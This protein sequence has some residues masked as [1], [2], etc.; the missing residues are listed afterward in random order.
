[1]K[2]SFGVVVMSAF[3]LGSGCKG[4]EKVTDVQCAPGAVAGVTEVTWT[5]ELEGDAHVE[6]GLQANKLDTS[7]P[8]VPAGAGSET[9]IGMKVATEYSVR[10]VVDDGKKVHESE[11][12]E[13]TT[14]P[15]PVTAPPFTLET[16]EPSLACEDGGYVMFN[17]LGDHESGVGI[18]DRDGRLV[19]AIES[20]RD[21]QYAR[22]RLG[23]DGTSIL[24]NTNDYARLE[25]IATIER[26]SIDGSTVTSTRAYQGHHDFLETAPGAFTFIGYEFLTNGEDGTPDLVG[27]GLTFDPAALGFPVDGEIIDDDPE[28]PRNDEVKGDWDDYPLAYDVLYEVAEGATDAD[29]PTLVWD[30]FR[31][32][33]E[34]VY[35]NHFN[36]AERCD[37]F[38]PDSCELGHANSL[39]YVPSEDRYTM[40]FRWL[41]AFVNLD[42]AGDVKWVLG[43]PSSTLDGPQ[44]ELPQ[45]AHFS[46]VWSGGMLAYDN[47]D[48]DPPTRL[49]EYS[50]TGDT[51]FDVVWQEDKD[52]PDADKVLGDLRR[53]PIEGCDNLLVVWAS[54]GRMEERTRDGQVAWAVSLP[55]G[56]IVGRAQYLSSLH[57]FAAEAAQ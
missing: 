3:V 43:G 21:T 31:D 35:H 18:L 50:L 10:V 44:E 42:Q 46:D 12:V 23:L 36:F 57:D 34:G 11:T 27:P 16:W 13:C 2:R 45:H 37:G 40:G 49:I 15:P 4:G 54:D 33:P 19:W 41:D 28:T 5:T 7:S 20:D 48:N 22:A 52:A 26:M 24:W 47:R 51:S 39:A 56:N 8:G 29:V 1:L 53:I 38:V 17:Y 14:A 32:W 6:Y 30:H 55:L 9:L 25:D